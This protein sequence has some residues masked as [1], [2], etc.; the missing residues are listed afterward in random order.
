[1]PRLRECMTLAALLGQSLAVPLKAQ[2]V[3][4]MRVVSGTLAF[5]GDATVGDFTGTTTSVTGALT[6]AASVEDVRGWV[7]A[8]ARTLVTGNGRRDRDM[9]KSLEVEQHPTLRFDLEGLAAGQ[10]EGDSIPVTLRGQ[11]TIHGVSRQHAVPGWLWLTPSNV[12]FR[13]RLPMNLKD[14][15]IGGLSKMLGM[16][17][18]NERIVVRVDVRFDS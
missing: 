12:R 5:D 1:M 10:P 18:M 3:P 14:Y 15:Q 7:E 9:Y 16:L 2:Q 13:G 6:A 4:A 11:F 17:K 8:P